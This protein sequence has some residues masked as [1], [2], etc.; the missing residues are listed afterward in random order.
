MIGKIIQGVY[1]AS[2][3]FERAA[4]R[5]GKSLAVTQVLRDPTLRHLFN[6]FYIS[7]CE[8]HIAHKFFESLLIHVTVKM[9]LIAKAHQIPVSLCQQTTLALP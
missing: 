5:V 4:H 8:E 9:A 3:Y 6:K 2:W 1:I 7:C